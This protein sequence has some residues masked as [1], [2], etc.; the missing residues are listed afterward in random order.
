LLKRKRKL[1]EHIEK[2]IAQRGE[3]EVLFTSQ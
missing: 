1:I 2:L 3:E